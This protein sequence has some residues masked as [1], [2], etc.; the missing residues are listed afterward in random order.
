M[1]HHVVL[2]RFVP[3]ASAEDI[4]SISQQFAALARQI[5]G[6][7]TLSGGPDVSPEGLQHGFTH[8]WLVQFVDAAA[9]D[10]YLVH[11]AHQAF[12]YMLKPFVDDVLVCDFSA[13]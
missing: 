4:A 5:P 8:G 3:A 10:A 2:M 12:V 7:L 6:I 11:P 13:H 9:R 1:L